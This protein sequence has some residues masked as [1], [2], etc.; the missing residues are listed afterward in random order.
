MLG[1]LFGSVC[2]VDITFDTEASTSCCK[3]SGLGLRVSDLGFRFGVL[4]Q[5]GL[6][7]NL[8]LWSLHLVR[9][10]GFKSAEP[11]HP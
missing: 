11:L 9:G 4:V 3:V 2:S 5:S 7:V 8:G 10:L 6:R 1:S